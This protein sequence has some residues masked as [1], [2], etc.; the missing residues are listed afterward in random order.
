MTCNA[1][2]LEG[3]KVFIE[4]PQA[5]NLMGKLAKLLLENHNKHNLLQ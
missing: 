5:E 4:L 3:A 1:V 2:T